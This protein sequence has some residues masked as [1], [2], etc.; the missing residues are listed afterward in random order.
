M[1]KKI[2]LKIKAIIKSASIYEFLFLDYYCPICERKIKRFVPLPNSFKENALKYEYKYFGQNEHLN[3]EQY[4]CPNCN[5]SDRDRLYATYIKMFVPTSPTMKKSLLH[6]APSWKLNDLF[7]K[8]YFE[9]TTTDLMME[10]VDYLMNVENMYHFND[11]SFDCFICSH[12]LEHVNYPDQAL[13]EL[14]RILKPGGFGIIM[15]P[16]I[17]GLDQTLENPEHLTKAER[18]KHYGQED[19]LRLFSRQDFIKRI[20]LANFKLRQFGISDFGEN[21]FKKLCLKKSSILY[22]GVK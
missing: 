21:S 20:E 8:K 7:L 10:G 9:I 2:K 5:S 22:I 1:L 18:M 17:P 4:S 11:N 14:Y 13:K 16:I 15:A 12:V 3:I 6:V 19:H